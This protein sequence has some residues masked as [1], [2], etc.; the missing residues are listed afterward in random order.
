MTWRVSNSFTLLRSLIL[1]PSVKEDTRSFMMMQGIYSGQDYSENRMTKTLSSGVNSSCPVI[2]SSDAD[3]LWRSMKFMRE[4]ADRFSKL[5]EESSAA[6]ESAMYYFL[7]RLLIHSGSFISLDPLDDTTT[8]S[9]RKEVFFVPSLLAQTDY[10]TD[11]W[12]FKS[13]ESWKATLCHTWLFRDGAPSNLMENIT[14][15]V[16]RAVYDLSNASP[17]WARRPERLRKSQTFT[18]TN[19]SVRMGGFADDDDSEALGRFRIDRVVC[20][21]SSIR[22]KISSSFIDPEKPGIREES[23]VDIFIALLDQ[24]SSHCV[25]SHAMRGS[26]QRVV[27]S[28]KG[29][30]G[31]H[32]RKLWK[33][34]YREVLDAVRRSLEELGSSSN[35]TSQVVCPD[36]LGDLSPSSACTWNWD[37]LLTD[38]ESGS[39]N[40]TCMRGHEVSS[41]LICGTC[42]ESSR[43]FHVPKQLMRPVSTI[44]P[45]VVLVGLWDCDEQVVS[46][47]GSGFIVDE[48][49]GLI[50]TAAHVLF[51]LN[52]GPDFGSRYFGRDA[53]V[54][55]GVIVPGNDHDAVWRYWAEVISEDIP[56]VDACIVRISSRMQNDVN[57]AGAGCAT[58]TETVLA[59]TPQE[60]LPSLR[61]KDEF[62][63]DEHVCILGFN[64]GGEGIFQKGERLNRTAGISK[65][66]ICKQFKASPLPSD[67][68][69]RSSRP[70]IK[71]LTPREEIVVQCP[72]IGGDSGGPCV[73]SMGAVVGILSRS[74][75]VETHRCYLVPASEIRP[76]IRR[77]Q[78]QCS[79][80]STTR[81]KKMKYTQSL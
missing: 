38:A 49:H 13:R 5:S 50:V 17:S 63:L 56:S 9:G 75:P 80:S 6:D 12:T 26:M 81:A 55:V 64:Q 34:G 69:P 78:L 22:I 11:M 48:R 62:E 24:S 71:T 74:D 4:A 59:N 20:W 51:D 28:G 45:S 8:L 46:V 25:A 7:E 30:V 52:D 58:Q 43:Q 67:T 16:L 41:H 65:G 72:T 42:S 61:L 73:N 23:Y 2:S 27:V 68:T 19:G 39:C 1:F 18:T 14:V 15:H 60:N 47:V 35:V 31:D 21:D 57:D 53:R 40:V 77:A 33:G 79:S 66:F 70:I 37:G 10:S 36:C 29:Q 3:M 32:G 54:V 44:L 76:L